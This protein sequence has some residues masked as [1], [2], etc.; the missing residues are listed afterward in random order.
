MRRKQHSQE[1]IA[2]KLRKD[3]RLLGRGTPLAAMCTHLEVTNQTYYW[4]R[5]QYR[6]MKAG[7]ATQLEEVE[8]ESAR[9]KRLVAT[10]VLDVDVL[11]EVNRGKFWVRLATR[12]LLIA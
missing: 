5:N 4:W 12:Q 6:R 10:Q 7:G 2:R 8:V 11:K 1:Q 3:N 9:L